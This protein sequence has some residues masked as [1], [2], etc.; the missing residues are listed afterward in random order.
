MATVVI[1]LVAL[2]GRLTDRQTLVRFGLPAAAPWDKIW[3]RL[4]L[5]GEP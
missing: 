5:L 4:P 2:V 1:C 3:R